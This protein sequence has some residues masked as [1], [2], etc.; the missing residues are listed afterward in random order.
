MRQKEGKGNGQQLL[1]LDKWASAEKP[2]ILCIR[3]G[4][5]FDRA[6]CCYLP[7]KPGKRAY[8]HIIIIV[9]LLPGKSEI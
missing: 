7:W 4:I 5:W 2:Q 1:S 8:F 9:Q 3:L 6:I